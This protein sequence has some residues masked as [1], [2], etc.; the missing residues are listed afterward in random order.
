[1]TKQKAA[2][3]R[4]GAGAGAVIAGVKASALTTTVPLTLDYSYTG[5]YIEGRERGND[6]LP[7]AI[8]NYI[9]QL[10]SDNGIPLRQ[11]PRTTA[12]RNLA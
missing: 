1:M 9:S 11:V 7:L 5:I 8:P 12:K 3:F 6:H 2:L 4:A 10:L